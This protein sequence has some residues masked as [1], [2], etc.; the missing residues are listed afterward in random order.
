MPRLV[1]SSRATLTTLREFA[2]ELLYRVPTDF[3][4]GHELLDDADRIGDRREGSYA[5]DMRHVVG[6]ALAGAG[7]D[8]VVDIG[9]DDGFLPDRVAGGGQAGRRHRQ[10]QVYVLVV[11][12]LK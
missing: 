8:R 7:G 9:E 10:N 6:A 1:K 12:V 3:T 4:A 11:V 2:S 5:G